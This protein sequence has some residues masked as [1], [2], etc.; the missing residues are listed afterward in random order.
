MSGILRPLGVRIRRGDTPVCRFLYKIGKSVLQFQI[1]VWRPFHSLLYAEWCMRRSLWHNFW[2][3]LYYEP[4]FKSQ[5]KTVGKNFVMEYAG[6]G[7]TRIF[8]DLQVSFGNNV[9]IFD[10]TQFV[11]L[12]IYCHKIQ[13]D[14]KMVTGQKAINDIIQSHCSGIKAI[15]IMYCI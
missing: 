3:V 1:P 6:N 12:K 5:C 9:Q 14:F 4:M 11:G 2:R 7:S 8:G 15:L 10:K 13:L